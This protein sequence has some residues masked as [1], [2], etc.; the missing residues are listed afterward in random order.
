MY[1][2]IP[3]IGQQSKRQDTETDISKKV[4]G[5]LDIMMMKKMDT[6]KV[7]LLEYFTF[8]IASLGVMNYLHVSFWSPLYLSVAISAGL[9][10]ILT[11]T[12][13]LAYF[14]SNLSTENRM[15][16]LELTQ[17]VLYFECA[18]FLCACGFLAMLWSEMAF[19]TPVV[20]S[21]SEKENW[22]GV[23]NVRILIGGNIR[24]DKTGE[25]LWYRVESFVFLTLFLFI[26]LFVLLSLTRMNVEESL[27][28]S[29]FGAFVFTLLQLFCGIQLSL[30]RIFKEICADFCEKEDL[31]LIVED[32]SASGN[33]IPEFSL[34]TGTLVLDCLVISCLSLGLI[35]QNLID[36]AILTRIVFIVLSLGILVSIE[37]LD[38]WLS[39]NTVVGTI[40]IIL[41]TASTLFSIYGIY[42]DF[43]MH[44]VRKKKAPADSE[45]TPS[46]QNS[47]AKKAIWMRMTTGNQQPFSVQAI[48]HAKI[49]KKE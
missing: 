24:L 39:Q 17:S 27:L 45:T 36:N 48:K 12:T 40:N 26:I 35:V 6:V 34:S 37:L 31:T 13:A 38:T 25:F 18:I 41:A 23:A 32:S 42:Y 19:P 49:S 29:H 30:E 3:T 10:F 21:G 4:K 8:W 20:I 5:E 11:S 22:A 7:L 44:R 15:K 46:Q 47:H 9:G 1:Q 43:V 16:I 28:K 14:T 2:I 33:S